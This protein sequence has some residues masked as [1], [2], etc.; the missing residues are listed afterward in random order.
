MR[1]FEFGTAS[2]PRNSENISERSGVQVRFLPVS[3][4][5]LSPAEGK[6]K[7]D[8][9]VL[10]LVHGATNPETKVRKLSKIFPN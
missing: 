7:F 6:G 8:Y 1:L 5:P 10:P 3:E 4:W 2:T 9:L